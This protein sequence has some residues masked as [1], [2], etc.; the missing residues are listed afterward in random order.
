MTANLRRL[1][2]DTNVY[3]IGIQDLNSPEA[4]ILK[5]IGYFGDSTVQVTA[6][7]ILSDEIIDQVRRVG[8]Y[9]WNKDKAGFAI[10]L[11]WSRL[12]VHY[13]NYNLE[14]K[15]ELEQITSYHQIPNEDIEVYLTA[16]LG[17]SDC[18]VSSNRELIKAIAAFKCLTPT[19]F[20]DQFLA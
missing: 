2:L 5:A 10:G 11:M 6:E 14:W 18:F 16:K 9:L 15:R 20:I 17:Q 1:C 4:R 12:N 13:V 3:I 7:I 19:E 8:K